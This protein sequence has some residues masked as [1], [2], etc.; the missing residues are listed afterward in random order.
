MWFNRNL[1]SIHDL[2]EWVKKLA[3]SMV[4]AFGYH[5]GKPNVTQVLICHWE[6]V[7]FNKPII[8]FLSSWFQLNHNLIGSENTSCGYDLALAI[9]REVWPIENMPAW[10]M[11]AGQRLKENCRILFKRAS[12]VPI[13]E[14]VGVQAITFV[15]ASFQVEPIQF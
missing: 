6:Y 2:H 9:L 8:P 3:T 4:V 5:N 1:I 13:Q 15:G 12:F 10:P 11:S 7:A 14:V